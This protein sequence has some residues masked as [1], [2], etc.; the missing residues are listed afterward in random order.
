MGYNAN[1][2]SASG[3]VNFLGSSFSGADIKLMVYCNHPNILKRHK[4]AQMASISSEYNRLTERL[5]TTTEVKEREILSESISILKNSLEQ[6]A[7]KSIG[8][9]GGLITLATVSSISV[10]AYREKHPVRAL[11][12][13]APKGFTRGGRTVAGSI[14]FAQ[15][16][17]HALM[18]FLYSPPTEWAHENIGLLTNP[19]QLPPMTIVAQFANEYGTLSELSIMGLEFVDDGLVLSIEDIYTEGTCTYVARD[20]N[21]LTKRGDIS[22]HQKTDGQSVIATTASALVRNLKND[23]DYTALEKRLNVRRRDPYR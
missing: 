4:E 2:K 17:E 11:G 20:Y 23:P 12:S 5:E 7:K 13:V 1:M 15:F 8:K 10:Q 3:T 6:L 21:V 9:S 22:L 14:V 16:D 18:D 19:D